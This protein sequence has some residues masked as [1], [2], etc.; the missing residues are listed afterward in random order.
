MPATIVLKKKRGTAPPE[1]HHQARRPKALRTPASPSQKEI[2][3][4][5]LTHIPYADWCEICR[6]C[7]RPNAAHHF[8]GEDDRSVPL[9]TVDYCF[10]HASDD[11]NPLPVAAARVRP[12]RLCLGTPVEA[13]GDNKEGVRMLS[14]FNN[15]QVELSMFGNAAKI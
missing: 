11:S 1:P 2:D 3:Q 12:A 13:K 9:L 15:T 6:G 5:V 10:L 7:R 4:H 8:K 14:Q